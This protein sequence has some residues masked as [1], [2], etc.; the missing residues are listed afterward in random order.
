MGKNIFVIGFTAIV[1][2]AHAHNGVA[3]ANSNPVT[4][5]T[6]S[7]TKVEIPKTPKVAS[8]YGYSFRSFVGV[9]NPG[10][11]NLKDGDMQ[12]HILALKYNMSEKWGWR[13]GSAYLV[14]NFNILDK[15][16]AGNTKMQNI[17][18]EGFSDLRLSAIYIALKDK[19]QSLDFSLG[20]NLP[21]AVTL[22]ND[23][24]KALPP[25]EQF[26]SGTYDIMP[27]V[28]YSYNLNDWAF[29]EKLDA[30]F[31]T[32]ENSIGYRL[33]DDFGFTTA[34]SYTAVPW[35]TPILSARYTDRKDL[36]VNNFWNPRSTNIRY[37]SG[38]EGAVGFRSGLPLT[39]NQNVRLGF[40][41]G[42]PIFRTS[43]TSQYVVGETLWYASTN[44][45][46]T[47]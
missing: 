10:P 37:G 36:A 22:K 47:Y 35:L 16:L 17:H 11:I 19:T 39:S 24:G 6:T 25:Q 38:W 21:T 2:V 7:A 33:G 40:E 41:A 46:A 26:S 34:V 1:V 8:Y 18:V 5:S 27:V 12:M 4:T 31:H 44:L 15:R 13:V 9:S 3:Q 30:V 32:G 29:S 14:H 43:R 20:L 28:N 23:D 45:T 42:A